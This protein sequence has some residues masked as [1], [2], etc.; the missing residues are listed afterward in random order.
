MEQ[1][2][3]DIEN[4]LN[5]LSDNGFILIHDCNPP[6]KFHQREN[7]CVDGTY[8]PWN[9]TVWKSLVRLRFN[10]DDL[11]VNVIDTDWVLV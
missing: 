11:K 2:D 9:G 8:P 1:V 7:Y 6:T 3:K 4:G 5:Y 10:R